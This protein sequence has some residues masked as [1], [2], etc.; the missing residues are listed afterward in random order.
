V[1]PPRAADLS[2]VVPTY[3]ERD[4]LTGLVHAVFDVAARH[5]LALELIVVDDNSPDGTGR[6]ADELAHTHR[7]IVIH[8]SGKLGLGSAVVTGF[9]SATSD[10]VGV[11]DADFS[12]PPALV[13][14]LLAALRSTGADMVVASRYIPG[15]GTV[16]WP[17]RRWFLSRLAC[18]L[19]S[20]LSPVRDATSGL[21]VIR[22]AV[23]ERAS[24]KAAGFK[25]CLE[26]L[27]RAWPEAIVEI[28]YVFENRRAGRSKMNAREGSGYLRQLRDLFGVV[29]SRTDRR[30]RYERWTAAQV[31]DAL[32][33]TTTGT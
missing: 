7:L 31:S 27:V 30:R 21:F 4:Q 19:A 17:W 16:N 32:R 2:L 14:A 28:P 11:M 8:R 1:A 24:V 22:R 5:A 6:V 23:A 10:V 26:L 3:N 33:Q 20:P 12:H 9:A 18:W 15:G 13:P 29:R 25:I